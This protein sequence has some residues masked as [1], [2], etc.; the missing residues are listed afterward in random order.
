MNL[1]PE[2]DVE[3]PLEDADAEVINLRTELWELLTSKNGLDWAE[4]TAIAFLD[5][6]KPEELNPD[7]LKGKFTIAR[8][9]VAAK[10]LNKR[11][12]QLL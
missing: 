6:R 10:S 7:E 1:L 9:M 2:P 8:D 12:H 5:G 3:E 4:S 11:Q